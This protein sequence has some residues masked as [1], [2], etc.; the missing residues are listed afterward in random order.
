[1]L[2]LADSG[3]TKTDW[4]LLCDGKI[5]GTFRTQGLN[6]YFVDT[7]DVVKV[8]EEHLIPNREITGVT[9]VFF[10]GAG[11]SSEEKNKVI[12]IALDRLF[13][14]S[15]N[16]VAHDMLAA[17]RALF[18]NQPGI[19]CI[20]GTGSNS[21]IYNGDQVT[22]SLFS[23]GYMFGDEGSGA[24]LGKTFIGAYLKKRVPEELRIDFRESYKLSD[25]DILTHIYRK[26]NPNRFLASFTHFLK[27][28]ER[29]PYVA[30]LIHSCFD[31]FFVEQIMKYPE[32][33]DLPAG[34][35]GSVA[36][37]FQDVFK[38]V[39]NKHGIGTALF[40]K[41]PMEGLIRYHGL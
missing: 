3:S 5:T 22:R 4:V 9:R 1:M 18:G 7:E 2:L 34:C 27:R 41:S 14:K 38:A 29:H 12:R 32:K 39:A 24:H 17:A 10:Y 40:M 35:I 19:A 28:H 33:N 37:H 6:P 31:S 8:L 25:E 20:L 13:P 23:L 11:C 30:D 21:C 16:V 36:Y 15:K 26:A